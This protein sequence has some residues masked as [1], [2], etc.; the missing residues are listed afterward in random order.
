MNVIKIIVGST[1]PQ[2]F[3]VQVGKWVAGVAQEFAASSGGSV[4]F[5][6][7]DLAEVNLPLLDEPF[8]AGMNKY[9]N[10]H[11]M[12][13]S[14][15]VAGADG[16]VVIT[17]EYNH[18]TSAAL[19]NALDYVFY[20]WNYKPVGFV[21]YGSGAGGA[22]AVEHLRGIVGELKMYDIRESVMVPN[23]WGQLG[24]DGAFTPLDEQTAGLK[25][26]LEQLA[27]WTDAMKPAREKLAAK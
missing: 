16:F 13:W 6:V 3:G 21:S 25:A 19:K 24:G 10:D 15:T 1:R 2:R 11:T 20:E 4:K 8:P 18:S 22:R 23:Y 5:E 26:M 7:V 27:Y 17:P 12:K 9:Q 14:A